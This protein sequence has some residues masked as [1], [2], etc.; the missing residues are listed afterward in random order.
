MSA[1]LSDE[2]M[3]TLKATIKEA[4]L[5]LL[6][7]LIREVVP[8][9]STI[10]TEIT[11]TIVKSTADVSREI[12]TQTLKQQKQRDTSETVFQTFVQNHKSELDVV[13]AKRC[14]SYKSFV[15]LDLR[16]RLYKEALEKTPVYI[17]K[18]YRNDKYYVHD[19]EELES[20]TKFELARFVSEMEIATKRRGYMLKEITQAD[21]KAMDIIKNAKL[22]QDVEDMALNR[23]KESTAREK[24]KIDEGIAKQEASTREAYAKD[25]AF[26]RKHQVD[27]LKKNGNPS[28]TISEADETSGYE[29]SQ[30]A[31]VP[32]VE[33]VV[34]PNESPLN[35]T[36]DNSNNKSASKNGTLANLEPPLELSETATMT[37][38]LDATE[39]AETAVL[40]RSE[41]KSSTC[42]PKT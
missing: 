40:R 33:L 10:I 32:N 6:P 38:L 26:L 16:V 29:K 2:V 11:P 19:E 31:D 21:E 18:K 3:D 28:T 17:P 5:E 27:R 4:I 36:P 13:F 22:T 1:V 15:S 37:P 12:N 42:L 30:W 23:W 14:E 9:I 20:V 25:E 8:V 7:V 41:R 34:V 39:L 24:K 35:A